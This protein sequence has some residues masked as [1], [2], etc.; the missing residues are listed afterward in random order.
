MRMTSAIVA[1]TPLRSST[2]GVKL[3]QFVAVGLPRRRAHA[4]IRS[5]VLDYIGP[6]SEA[7][8]SFVRRLRNPCS[9]WKG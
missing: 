2:G 9:C 8:S 1:L 7:T 5:M 3:I 6:I 4:H